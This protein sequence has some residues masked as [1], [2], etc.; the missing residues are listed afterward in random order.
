MTVTPNR[1]MA[2]KTVRMKIDGIRG[3][4]QELAGT[5]TGKKSGRVERIPVLKI[6]ILPNTTTIRNSE[7]WGPIVLLKLSLLFL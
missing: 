7:A 6:R 2:L 1:R 3:C 5:M 4:H